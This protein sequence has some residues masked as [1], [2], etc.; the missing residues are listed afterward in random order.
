MYNNRRANN[1]SP[2]KNR[3]AQNFNDNFTGNINIY[4]K[5]ENF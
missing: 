3:N 2:G 5:L 1:Y 4:G